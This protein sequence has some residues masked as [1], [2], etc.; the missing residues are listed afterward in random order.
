MV[1][2]QQAN[3]DQVQRRAK[4]LERVSGVPFLSEWLTPFLPPN[5]IIRERTNQGREKRK[6]VA[7]FLSVE[8]YL[9]N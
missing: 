4:E 6:L 9:K 3:L 5:P 1:L 7:H 2:K 8:G